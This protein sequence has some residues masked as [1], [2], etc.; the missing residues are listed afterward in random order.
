MVL[1]RLFFFKCNV[2]PYFIKKGIIHMHIYIDAS[3]HPKTRQCGV[4]IV[5]QTKTKHETFS[6]PLLC[7]YNN[8]EAEFIALNITLRYL[9]DEFIDESIIIHSDSQ[10]VVEA[11]SH[12]RVKNAALKELYYIAQQRLKALPHVFIQWIP[13]K[14][15]KEADRLARNAMHASKRLVHPLN[16]DQF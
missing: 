13:E 3:C 5:I 1:S 10:T 4:G 9:K 2:T 16:K 11:Y 12:Q 7:H 15:N 14:Q 8:H 6:I